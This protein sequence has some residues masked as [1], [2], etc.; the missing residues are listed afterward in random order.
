MDS[1]PYGTPPRWW[2]PCLDPLFFRAIRPARQMWQRR[3]ERVRAVEVRGLE[4]L[5]GAVGADQGVVLTPNHATHSDPFVFL[6]VSDRVDRPFY[7]MAAWQSFQI[8]PPVAR[9]VIRRHGCFSVDREGHDVRAF[10]RAVDIVSREPHPLVIFPEGEVY[11][12]ADQVVPFREGAAAIALAAAR[13]ARRPVVALPAAVRYRYLADPTPELGRLVGRMERKLAQPPRPGLPLAERLARLAGTVLE[14]R[15]RQFLGRAQAG[16]FVPRLAALIE[17]I[18]GPIEARYGLT[19][20]DLEDVPGRATRLRRRAIQEKEGRPDGDPRG[21]QAG[22]DLDAVAVAVQLFSYVNDYRSDRPSLEHLAEIV[23]KFEEDIL[24]V[25]TARPRG[26]R[27]AVVLFGPPV[28]V[29]PFR[30]PEGTAALTRT[31]ENKVRGL[32]EELTGGRPLAPAL[33]GPA[34]PLARNGAGE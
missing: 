11:H 9:W 26:A 24:G 12:N 6:A 32:L 21:R 20:E 30:G 34:R 31:L 2:S 27:R 33:A 4:H 29:A 23:D 28:P 3:R 5:R 7:Y 18:V 22:Q 25:Q 10:R 16:P 17:A 15:E 13:R 19:P 1:F 8:L 14:R